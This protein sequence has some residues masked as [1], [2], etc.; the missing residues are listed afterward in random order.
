ML[1]DRENSDRFRQIST[2]KPD[3]VEFRLDKIRE[4]TT[5]DRICRKK[6]LPTIVTDRSRRKVTSNLIMAAVDAGVEY[7]DIDLSDP[8]AKPMIK[9][10]KSKGTKV[11]ASIHNFVETPSISKLKKILNAQVEV[12]GDVCKIATTAQH[13]R[14][15]LAILEFLERESAENKLVAFAMGSLGIPSRILSPVFGAEFTFAALGAKTKTAEGQ[16]TIDNLRSVW[17]LL[18]IQ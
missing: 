8:C 9:E 12:G 14:D 1:N 15:N 7:V 13:P 3:L 5:V 6:T 2:K 10:I 16:L 18:G 17:K 11:I 4:P